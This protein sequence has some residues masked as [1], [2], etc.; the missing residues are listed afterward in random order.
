LRYLFNSF[1]FVKE[2]PLLGQ[3][4]FVKLLRRVAQFSELFAMLVWASSQTHSG[5]LQRTGLMDEILLSG[6]TET[7]SF[8]SSL[9]QAEYDAFR[10]RSALIAFLKSNW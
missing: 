3:F 9:R 1:S 10:S 2:L 5:I 7:D 8:I 4:D 6:M